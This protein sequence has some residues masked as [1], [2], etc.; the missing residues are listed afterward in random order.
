MDNDIK[1]VLDREKPIAEKLYNEDNNEIYGCDTSIGR[2]LFCVP[3]IESGSLK[4]KE[5]AQLLI[6]WLVKS[7]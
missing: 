6:R 3:F 4:R 7:N 5:P 2:V 1:K